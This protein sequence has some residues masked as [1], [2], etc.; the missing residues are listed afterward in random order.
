M[1]D[2]VPDEQPWRKATVSPRAINHRTVRTSTRGD[3]DPENAGVAA[4]VPA[5]P[6]GTLP[7]EQGGPMKDFPLGPSASVRT[8]WESARRDSRRP[9][10]TGN[11]IVSRDGPPPAPRGQPPSIQSSRS[12][13]ATT[14]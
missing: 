13:G 1:D 3:L 12:G 10:S 2:P 7:S 14:R 5:E 6:G 11:T 8:A 4:W 9:S